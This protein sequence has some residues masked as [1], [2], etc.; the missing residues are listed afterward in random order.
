MFRILIADDEG[1]MRQSI[2]KTIEGSFGSE[3]EIALAK[4]GREVIE[5]CDT[6]RPDIAFVDIQMPGISGIQAIEEVQ[7]RYDGI[8]FVIISAYD[9]FT[10]AQEAINLGVMD[11]ITKPVSKKTVLDVCVKAM[12]QVEETRSR[13]SDDL[14]IREKLEIVVPMIESSFIYNLISQ[15]E[16]EQRQNYLNMLDIDEEY[17]YVILIKFG[18][19]KEKGKFANELGSSVRINRNYAML[20]EIIGDYEK[21][22]IGPIMGNQLVLY[23]P[24]D[25]AALTYE[26]RV[27]L[28]TRY[29]GLRSKLEEK[30]E[31]EFFFGISN[32]RHISESDLSYK[33]A[34]R[35]V[36]RGSG[37]IVHAVDL[38][39]V[40]P[41]RIYPHEF[42]DQFIQY[43][44]QS[45]KIGIEEVIE[46]IYHWFSG[47]EDIELGSI[48]MKLLRLLLRLEGK[49]IDMEILGGI[50]D[51][52]I[53]NM[54]AVSGINNVE[55]LFKWFKA[56]SILLC[57][58]IELEQRTSTDSVVERSI[59]YIKGH[60][61][62][63]LTLDE[64]SQLVDVSPY[65]FSK[66]FKQT[67]GETFIEYLTAFRMEKAKEFLSNKKYSIKEVCGMCGYNDP[68]Y[69]SRIFKKYE[70]KTPS[71]FR[72]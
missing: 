53:T 30:I 63:N 37:H 58:S 32:V 28:I 5:Q 66:L 34:R 13:R 15:D 14:A 72:D 8:V 64:V 12:H 6:F 69:F 41:E 1:I 60:Y 22:V 19:Y 7:K 40:A 45:D 31:L 44:L 18:E 50:N 65:Y 20:R 59:S 29:R 67:T 9:K 70:G 4:T 38:H 49:A 24:V 39:A 52:G 54:E 55:E 23:V 56:E 62:D 35:C 3:V 11:Y 2:Q 36:Q 25:K 42:D 71:E 61:M 33:E 51:R 57:D 26:E 48:K 47:Q 16:R 43:G 17:G 46:N 68:N 10:Y 27:E 21:C